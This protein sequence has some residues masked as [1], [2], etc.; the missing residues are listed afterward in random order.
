M[1]WGSR[2]IFAG[3]MGMMHISG[4]ASA[5]ACASL[6]DTCLQMW[7]VNDNILSS[8]QTAMQEMEQTAL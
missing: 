6:T 8:M 4:H 7:S 1:T 2:K 5:C 3:V